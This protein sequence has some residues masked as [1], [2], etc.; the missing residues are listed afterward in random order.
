MDKEVAIPNSKCSVLYT[1]NAMQVTERLSSFLSNTNICKTSCWFSI[2]SP[3]F[4]LPLMPSAVQL[5]HHQSM[6]DVP[7][8]A[9]CVQKRKNWNQ[10]PSRH[11]NH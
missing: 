4:L 6:L 9:H 2:F 8:V 11:L 5:S 1:K 7:R 10:H 3:L